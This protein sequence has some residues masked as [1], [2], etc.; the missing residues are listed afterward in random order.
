MSSRFA[1]AVRHADGI[2]DNKLKV[3]ISSVKLAMST[4]VDSF[5]AVEAH[6]E[7][8]ALKAQ[9]IEEMRA[10]ADEGL[11]ASHRGVLQIR[12]LRDAAKA[13]TRDAVFADKYDDELTKRTAE[14][15]P[16]AVAKEMAKDK[17]DM[18][19]LLASLVEGGD[20]PAVFAAPDKSEES[21]KC[22]VTRQ[23]MTDPVRNSTCNHVYERSGIASLQKPGKPWTCPIPGCKKAIAELIADTDTLA[24][25]ADY[26]KA[27]QDDKEEEDEEDA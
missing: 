24:R 9:L 17:A 1:A 3:L 13:V 11:E 27:H 4:T 25:L 16:A 22:K 7:D 8:E 6:V 19:K 26:K 20:E 10:F 18:S 14:P 15:E 12:A 2:D 5:P 21:L 23:L